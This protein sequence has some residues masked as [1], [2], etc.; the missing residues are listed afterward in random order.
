MVFPN[1]WRTPGQRERKEEFPKRTKKNN[2][3]N[4]GIVIKDTVPKKTGKNTYKS[5]S[6]RKFTTKQVGMYYAKNG[7]KKK[8]KKKKWIN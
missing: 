7:F 2:F 6:G 1:G 4:A 8:P 3:I 5:P